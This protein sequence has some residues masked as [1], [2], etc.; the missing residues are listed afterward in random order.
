MS[1]HISSFMATIIHFIAHETIFGVVWTKKKKNKFCAND[2]EVPNLVLS[3]E[4]P[5]NIHIPIYTQ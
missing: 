1:A 2:V 5:T 4:I 3:D